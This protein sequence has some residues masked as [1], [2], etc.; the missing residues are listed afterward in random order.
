MKERKIDS[1]TISYIVIS[2]FAI[3]FFIAI[4]GVKVLDFQN[5]D[6]LYG[7]YE[8]RRLF[9]WQILRSIIWDGYVIDSQIG[10]S[11]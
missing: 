4:Y 8:V 7:H 10:H 2:V 9:L 5:V 3:I 6:W 11:Q 1:V